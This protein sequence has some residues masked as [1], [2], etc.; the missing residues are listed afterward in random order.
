[1][2]GTAQHL[3]DPRALIDAGLGRGQPCH[4]SCFLQRG[5]FMRAAVQQRK[6]LAVDV[7]HD[8]I[9][10]CDVDDLVAAGQDVAGSRDDVTGH[11][12]QNL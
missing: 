4:T 2:P 11:V 6:E 12:D 1:M 8:D 9:A 5:A 7:E 3:P 10:A